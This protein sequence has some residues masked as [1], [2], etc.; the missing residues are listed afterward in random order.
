MNDH[1]M[2]LAA[3]W[4]DTAIVAALLLAATVFLG[5]LTVRFFRGQ[6]TCSCSGAR[7]GCPIAQ[8][9]AAL[10]RMAEAANEKDQD[11]LVDTP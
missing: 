8:A 9:P 11:E 5:I 2:I 6:T 7:K 3:S 4:I 10:E 1:E